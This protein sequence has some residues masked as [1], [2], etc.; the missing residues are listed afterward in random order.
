MASSRQENNCDHKVLM[1]QAWAAT[2]WR[3]VNTRRALVVGEFSRGVA[4]RRLAGESHRRVLGLDCRID[5]RRRDSLASEQPA[6]T[7]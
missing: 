3:C 2:S 4:S 7:P 5:H 6:L 1:P